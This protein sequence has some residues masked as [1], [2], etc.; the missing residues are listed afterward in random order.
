MFPMG[1]GV[2]LAFVG[3]LVLLPALFREGPPLPTPDFRAFVF[4]VIALIA[5]AVTIRWL[6]LIPAI[7][8]V[9]VASVLAD[10]KLGIVGTVVLAAG[11]S[12]MGW[13]IFNVGLGIPLEP[14]RSPWR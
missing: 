8:L 10:N 6:G 2:L 12:L 7:V 14:F 9:T 3:L 4:V 1:L 11:L 5:F 13:L